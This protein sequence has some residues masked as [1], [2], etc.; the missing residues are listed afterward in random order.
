MDR[1]RGERQ[2][3][4]RESAREDSSRERGGECAVGDGG[5][6][7]ESETDEEAADQEELNRSDSLRVRWKASPPIDDTRKRL[8]REIGEH[9]V[10][11]RPKFASISASEMNE[12]EDTN[13]YL[14]ATSE[15]GCVRGAHRPRTTT[16]IFLQDHSE[17]RESETEGGDSGNES[18]GH[19]A[20]NP[21]SVAHSDTSVAGHCTPVDGGVM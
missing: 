11:R 9:Q 10:S 5:G 20:L 8:L 21:A 6:E 3:L 17:R 7:S 1:E 4:G 2:C 15:Y 19:G 18:M 12:D 14:R 16:A 13:H